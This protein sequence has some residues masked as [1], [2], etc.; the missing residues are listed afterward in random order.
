MIKS[1][2]AFAIDK[3]II[4]HILM[5]FML[6]LSLFAYQDISKEIFPPSELDQ[7][8]V[9]GGYPGAS[10]DVLDKM[11]VKSI[12][13]EMKSISE[14]DTIETV[15]QNGFFTMK[16]DIKPGSDNQLVLGDV[17]D[18]I[19]NIRRDLPSDMDEPIAKITVHDFPLLLVAISGKVPKRKLLDI[20]EDLKSKLS[21]YKDLS[22]I[23]IR[24]DADDEVLIE[25]DNAKLTAYNLPKESVY[26]AI[27][28][29]SSIF[30]IG[31]IEQKGSH[32]YLS[33][34][35]GEKSAKALESTYL[36]IA[37]KR[38]RIG[39]IAHVK[40]GLSESREISHFNGVQNISL[41]INKTRHGNAIALSREIKAML[42]AAQ[43]NYKNV[44]FEAYTDTS[45]WIKNRLNLVSS[46][47]VFGLIL[48]FLALFLSVNYKIAL[49]SR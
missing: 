26:H 24:G 41:N 5:L 49:V 38:L 3:P 14:I 42:K 46:N 9:S 32:L 12:E 22:G 2:I 28:S 43:K 10:A 23:T 36:T 21:L 16:A 25:I 39:D 4:N 1:F 31:T 19:A 48:V 17:K 47:I 37:G 29:L 7:I 27:A 15:I 45:V 33:T 8:T 18:V 13:D 34:I 30:P 40:F 44:S 35:N 20:A 6:L 11:A